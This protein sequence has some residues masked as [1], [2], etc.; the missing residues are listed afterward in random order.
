MIIIT[1]EFYISSHTIDYGLRF[2]NLDPNQ[3]YLIKKKKLE[4]V[5]NRFLHNMLAYIR[6]NVEL[7]LKSLS[8]KFNIENL[9]FHKAIQ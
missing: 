2:D 7:S 3:G 1:C 4:R 8:F 9:E 5:Q 6:G